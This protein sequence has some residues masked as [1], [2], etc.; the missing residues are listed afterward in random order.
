M[1]DHNSNR[2]MSSMSGF[3][4]AGTLR[5]CAY[6]CDSGDVVITVWRLM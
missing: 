5:N 6:P 4:L 2:R 1:P 3:G